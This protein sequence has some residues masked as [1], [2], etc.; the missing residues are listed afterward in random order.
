MTATEFW[1]G[2]RVTLTGHSGFKGAW[3]ALWLTDLGARV[4]GISLPPP[5]D[6]AFVAMGPWPS[7]DAKYLD[8]RNVED[9]AAAVADS[10]PQVIFHLAAQALVRA[11]YERP[12]ETYDT[13]VMGTANLLYSSAAAPDLEAVVVVTSDK[14]YAN[15]GTGRHFLE[16]D[17]LGHADPYSSSKACAELVVDTWRQTAMPAGVHAATARA[18]NVIGGGD[19]SPDRLLPDMFRA[20]E[21]NDPLVLRYP[22]SVRPWQHVL[23]PLDGYLRLAEHLVTKGDSTPHAVNFGPDDAAARSVAEVAAL[24]KTLCGRGSWTSAA[25]AQPP[26]APVL[27]LDSSLARAA[28]GWQPRLNLPEALRLTV[29]WHDAARQGDDMRAFSL[30]QIRAYEETLRP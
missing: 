25:Q 8:I 23:E 14:V 30:N 19:V 10:N 21:R 22:A 28:L 15:E 1:Q 9:I 6:G 18:G 17:R 20:L 24:M 29:A 16:G 5:G 13:N 3:L 12:L 26:E 27:R 2:R 4:T 11:G 7:L